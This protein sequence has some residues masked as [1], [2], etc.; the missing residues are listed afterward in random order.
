M[1]I[2]ARTEVDFW[3]DQWSV[4]KSSGRIQAAL[5][6]TQFGK[7]G[8]FLRVIEKHAPGVVDGR[9]VIELGGAASAFLVDFAL[10]MNAEVTAVD[11]SPVGIAETEQ[12]FVRHG[13]DGR[14]VLGDIFDLG[15]IG[16]FDVVTHWGLVEHFD[17]PLPVLKASADLLEPS[18][19]LIFSMPNMAA[20]GA[21]LWQRHAPENFDAHIFH[22][23]TALKEAGLEVG[24]HMENAFYFGEPLVRMA[25]SEKHT[26]TSFFSNALHAGFLALGVAAPWLYTAGHSAI[27]ANR[28]FLMR[29]IT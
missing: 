11:Y 19:Y 8:Q 23:T 10:H 25:P 3:D 17:D 20:M 9:R 21:K 18:G 12:M 4:R 28:G 22:S 1:N 16:T 24:L 29:K 6:S 27:S 26:I 14:A 15:N 2:S 13:V 7:R 5:R